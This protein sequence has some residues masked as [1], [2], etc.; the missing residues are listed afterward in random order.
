MKNGKLD[1]DESC[2]RTLAFSKA[3]NETILKTLRTTLTTNLKRCCTKCQYGSYELATEINSISGDHTVL[4]CEHIDVCKIIDSEDSY[5]FV[6]SE[7]F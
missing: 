5:L 7:C 2:E 1:F 3:A 4:T 6:D